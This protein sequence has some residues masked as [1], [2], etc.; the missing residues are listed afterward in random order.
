MWTRVSVAAQDSTAPAPRATGTPAPPRPSSPAATYASHRSFHPTP[1]PWSNQARRTTRWRAVRQAGLRCRRGAWRLTLEKNSPDRGDILSDA[2]AVTGLAGMELRRT[3]R[4]VLVRVGEVFL[5]GCQC[6]RKARITS[7]RLNT[8]RRYGCLWS[9]HK[10]RTRQQHV[11][12]IL[13]KSPSRWSPKC[14]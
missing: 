2:V 13:R 1:T 8:E 11:V 3:D 4:A 14:R 7:F 9:V 5:Q 6:K 10:S 12:S